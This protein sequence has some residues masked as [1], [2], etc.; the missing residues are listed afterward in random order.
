MPP[1]ASVPNRGERP[2][3]RQRR[4]DVAAVREL[5]GLLG[6]AGAITRLRLKARER[7]LSRTQWLL[8]LWAHGRLIEQAEPN[9]PDE[10]ELVELLTQT[11]DAREVTGQASATHAAACAYPAHRASD[12]IASGGRRICGICHP[13]ASRNES[14]ARD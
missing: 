13:P 11:F 14:C 10:E 6:R 5:A 3:D 12:W 9:P 8:A 4:R 1:R 7:R 2:E